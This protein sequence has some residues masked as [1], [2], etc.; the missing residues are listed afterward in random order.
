MNPHLSVGLSA[1]RDVG[2]A[3]IKLRDEREE[4]SEKMSTAAHNLDEVP[5]HI[6]EAEQALLL[7]D[8][9]W[10][11]AR[12]RPRVRACIA[13]IKA[14]Y[15]EILR[16]LDGIPAMADLNRLAERAWWTAWAAA[17]TPAFSPCDWCGH[18][19]VVN[20]GRLERAARERTF[21]IR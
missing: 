4:K 2:E 14:V 10:T 17:D 18:T 9:R 13:E 19:L 7:D 1:G 15:G 3:R 6:I 16:M 8:D 5:Q 20:I 11:D 12:T 21:C